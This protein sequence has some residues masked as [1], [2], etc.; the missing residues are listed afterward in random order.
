MTEHINYD[1]LARFE[2]GRLLWKN[3]QFRQRLINHWLDPRHP[4][5]ERFLEQCEL[6]ELVLTATEDD[7]ALDARL[8]SRGTSLRA[9]IRE[10]PP[11]FGSFW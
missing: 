7:T 3:P 10:I 6:I 11:V 1:D 5:R 8:R 4:Y 2:Y 9:I